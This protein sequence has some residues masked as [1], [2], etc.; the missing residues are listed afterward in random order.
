MLQYQNIEGLQGNIG[1]IYFLQI[2]LQHV[3]LT[4]RIDT[5]I[6]FPGYIETTDVIGV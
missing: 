1:R 4:V 5:Y 3:K 2:S 6:E